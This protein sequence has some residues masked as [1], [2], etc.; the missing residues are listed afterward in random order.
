MIRAFAVA[1]GIALSFGIVS[2]EPKKAPARKAAKKKAA[3]R[4]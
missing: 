2:A 1:L 3:R 4:R